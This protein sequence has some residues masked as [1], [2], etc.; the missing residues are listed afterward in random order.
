MIVGYD[1][2]TAGTI[3]TLGIPVQFSETPGD[4]RLPA[5]LLGEHTNEI[6]S[7]YGGYT[8]DEMRMLQATGV[9]YTGGQ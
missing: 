4:I 7:V 5:P 9:T 3:R 2:P 8:G 6:L 1:H